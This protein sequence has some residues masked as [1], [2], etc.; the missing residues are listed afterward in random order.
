MDSRLRLIALLLLCAVL[1]ALW[2]L[3]L[4][5][6]E[7]PPASLHSADQR[8]ATL[9][10]ERAD[11]EASISGP[12]TRSLEPDSAG[13]TG[14]SASGDRFAEASGGP[15]DRSAVATLLKGSGEVLFAVEDAAGRRLRDVS[16]TLRQL[17]RGGGADHAITGGRG[18]AR[19]LGLA[20]G[21]YSY[22]AQAPDRLEV[23][24]EASFRLEDGER[25]QVTVRLGGSNL[26]IMGRVRNQHG[27]PIP[28]IVV[29]AVRHRFASSVSEDESG[30]GSMQMTLS[31]EDGSFAIGGLAE[32][33]YEVQTAA[34]RLY[35]SLKLT[36]QAGAISADLILV[37]GFAVDGTVKNEDGE[38]LARVWVGLREQRNRFAYTDDAGRYRLRLDFAGQ[39]PGSTVRFF[40]AGYEEQLLGL[41]VPE[42]EGVRELR[43]DAE[44]RPVENAPSVVGVVRTERG[45]P[46]ARASV[47]LGSLE[48]GTHYQAVSDPQGYFAIPDVVVGS[49]YQL[50]VLPDGSFL[51]YSRRPIRVPDDG[52]SFEIVLEA[53]ATGRLTG[54][55]IDVDG[56]PVPGFRLWLFNNGASRSGLPLSSDERGYFELAEAP[57][58]S[59][60]FAT[61]GAPQHTVSGVSLPA[62]GE[63][64]VSLILDWGALVMAGEVLGDRGDPVGGA[65]VSLSWSDTNGAIRST[66]SRTMRTDPSGLFRF[67]RLGPGEHVLEVR[68]AA[69]RVV[70]ER[71][72]VGQYA[73][74]VEVRLERDG[75]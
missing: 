22:R 52:L 11:P 26:S 28:G 48:L 42:P 18:E 49:G 15:N 10:V 60:T 8:Q 2:L 61:R 20:P 3:S 25:K 38:P 45:D 62:G 63:R 29:S 71:H 65:L 66:S 5:S 59:L 32:G 44:L 31:R 9:E 23:V 57:A 33:E 68:A 4:R 41:P 34:T 19:F 47:V 55:M 67:T 74:E 40:L 64:E 30:D 72:D 24:S 54:R 17:D 56:H 35:A 7:D 53:L 58:G 13:G 1:S 39:P 70:Q 69:Y 37:E 27:E 73:G 75:S 21:S 14:E 51:D 50:R 16:V 46:I 36:F 6:D 43:L 12:Q